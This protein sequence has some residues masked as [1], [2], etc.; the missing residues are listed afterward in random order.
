MNNNK[1]EYIPVKYEQK[2]SKIKIVNDK[3]VENWPGVKSGYL[4][5][6]DAIEMFNSYFN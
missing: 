6:E 2:R 5:K 3:D 1:Y 4:N